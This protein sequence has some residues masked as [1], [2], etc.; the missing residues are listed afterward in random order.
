M[1][2]GAQLYSAH[3]RLQTLE[4]FDAGL[5]KVAEIGYRT[6]QVSGTCPYEPEWLRDTLQK[7]NLTCC[8]THINPERIVNETEKVV[9]E[10]KI[11]GCTHIG[12]GGMPGPMRK[13]IEGYEAF[14]DQ[15]LPAAQK[16]RDLGAKLH[17]H[18]HWF[19]FNELEGKQIIQ[20]IL[21]DFPA[22]VLDF[23]LDLGWAAYG[24]ADV[25]AL[26]RQMEGRL[27]APLCSISETKAPLDAAPEIGL[28]TSRGTIS[29]GIPTPPNMGDRSSV[30]RSTAPDATNI[31]SATITAQRDGKS[32]AAVF[33]PSVAP[34]QKAAK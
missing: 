24:G 33:I 34:R 15:F 7:H 27:S 29:A 21:E 23:T 32:L 26:I 14:R 6:V 22:D 9:A 25:L 18:N 8:I 17:Y 10:H 13:T 28:V 2:I 19:E 3:K 5:K 4:D 1:Q 20:R 31:R 16:I 30:T 12:I 11:F